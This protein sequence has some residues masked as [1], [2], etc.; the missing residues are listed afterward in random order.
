MYIKDRLTLQNLSD[1]EWRQ[2]R[3]QLKESFAGKQIIN[4]RE[5][6]WRQFRTQLETSFGMTWREEE[7]NQF[8]V[9][10]KATFAR[11]VMTTWKDEEWL[12]FR[13]QLEKNLAT[14]GTGNWKHEEWS[15]SREQMEWKAEEWHQSHKQLQ[16][17]SAEKELEISK[18][19]ELRQFRV[20]Q[21][22]STG[23]QMMNSK[24]NSTADFYS[25]THSTGTLVLSNGFKGPA[26]FAKSS[27]KTTNGVNSVRS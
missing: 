6:E 22:D 9:Y 4:W 19:T 23:K 5:E 11:K 1:Y 7:W 12:Q 18:V 26:N 21:E 24:D 10:L 14:K 27:I 2:F 16:E 17:N 25:G 15:Q 8:R 13:V 3:L 20:Q